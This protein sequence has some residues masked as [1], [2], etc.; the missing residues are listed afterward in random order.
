MKK[1]YIINWTD[2]ELEVHATLKGAQEVVLNTYL[3]DNNI[4]T[5]LAKKDLEQLAKENYIE[6]YAWIDEYSIFE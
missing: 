6:D 3:E 5:D 1:V 4:E 2:G